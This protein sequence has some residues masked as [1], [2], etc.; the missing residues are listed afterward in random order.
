MCTASPSCPVFFLIKL[1]NLF[2]HYYSF[3]KN[4]YFVF[5]S[6][7][8]TYAMVKHSKIIL[9]LFLDLQPTIVFWN[10]ML[11]YYRVQQDNHFLSI[12]YKYIKTY[13]VSPKDAYRLSFVTYKLWSRQLY[14]RRAKVYV[15]TRFKCMIELVT[16]ST[17]QKILT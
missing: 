16:K 2:L 10:R 8:N 5:V 12:G 14:E 1:F 11:Q 7:L 13:V 4:K 3:L 17:R 9:S 15:K 6:R